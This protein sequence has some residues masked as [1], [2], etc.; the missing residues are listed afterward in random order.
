MVSR[1]L[2]R[3]TLSA[4]L[5][6]LI[7]R[8]GLSRYRICKEI[9]LAESAMSRFMSG[10]AGLSLEVLDRLFRLLGL[11][12][13]AGGSKTKEGEPCES[14]PLPTRRTARRS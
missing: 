6:P 10:E 2:R 9:G 1:M 3:D 12:V 5:R 13:V 11:R 8:S 7:D 4:Q 14:D